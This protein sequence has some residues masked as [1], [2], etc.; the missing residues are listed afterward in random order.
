MLDAVRSAIKELG[1]VDPRDL[2]DEEL[3]EVVVEMQ[4]LRDAAHAVHA[5]VAGLW[6]ARRVWAS[7]GA[8]SG[9]PWLARKTRASEAACGSLLWLARQR[10]AMPVAAAAW[11]AGEIGADHLNRLAAVRNHRTEEALAQ[12]EALLVDKARTHSF[13][14]FAFVVAYWSQ[15]ADPEGADQDYLDRRDRRRFSFDETI[16][17]MWSTQGVLDPIGGTIIATELRRLEHKLFEADWAEAKKR[18]G[19]DP[20]LHELARTSDQRRADALQ[21]MA[22]RSACVPA[23]AK[24]PRTLLTV[25]VGAERFAKLLQ[26]LSGAV[27]PP[28]AVVPLLA[29]ADIEGL[30]FEKTGERA[31]AASRTR[32]FKGA[33]RRILDVRDRQCFHDFCEEPADRC[34]GDHIVPYGEGGMTAQENGRLA[35][36]FHNRDRHRKRPPPTGDDD[37]DEED[38]GD[39]P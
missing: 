3:S 1:E 22:T 11:D 35:C 17:G 5:K 13:S 14:G 10:A 29:D 16:G 34:Q 32:S 31:I 28:A 12:D 4:A 39:D 36:G 15:L 9:K 18:L 8:K 37:D 26:L 19:R 30:L 24:R 38:D 33:M 6:D 7:D 23:N 27:V 21:E 25:V 2:T 20:H